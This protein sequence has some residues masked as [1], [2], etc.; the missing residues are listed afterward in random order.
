MTESA[1]SI[2]QDIHGVDRVEVVSRE[3]TSSKTIVIVREEGDN[4]GITAYTPH[5]EEDSPKMVIE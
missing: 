2:T 5:G 1:S 3:S 4:V